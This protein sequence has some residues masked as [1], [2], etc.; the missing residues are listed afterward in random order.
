MERAA[1]V[2]GWPCPLEGKCRVFKW[3]LQRKGCES[4]RQC[5]GDRAGQPLPA[6]PRPLPPSLVPTQPPP[7][8]AAQLIGHWVIYPKQVT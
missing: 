2:H 5:R 7:A 1:D 6:L 3:Q 4:P 8:A